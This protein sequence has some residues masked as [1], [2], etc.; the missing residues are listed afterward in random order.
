M[1]RYA[2]LYALY[3][4]KRVSKKNKLENILNFTIHYTL[5]EK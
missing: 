2:T 1:Q 4:K 3:W 5:E